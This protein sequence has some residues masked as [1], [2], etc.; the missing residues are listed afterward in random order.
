MRNNRVANKSHVGAGV[1][2]ASDAAYDYPT[3]FQ[4]MM[5]ENTTIAAP[6]PALAATAG[7]AQ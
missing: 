2:A 3:L 1:D 5:G 7:G 4:V 6:A